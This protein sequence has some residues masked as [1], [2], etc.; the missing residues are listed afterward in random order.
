[1]IHRLVKAPKPL[2]SRRADLVFLCWSTIISILLA[3]R[4]ATNAVWGELMWIVD[5]DKPGGIPLFIATQQQVWYQALGTSSSVVL[6]L[7]NDALMVCFLCYAHRKDTYS[8]VCH[9]IWRCYI[10]WE[11]KFSVIA[12]PLFLYIASI[13]ESKYEVVHPYSDD[14]WSSIGFRRTVLIIH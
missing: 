6:L 11:L 4:N 12:V 8:Y 13:R 1:M 9:Q 14:I 5:R 2:S 10:V 7:M 3:F